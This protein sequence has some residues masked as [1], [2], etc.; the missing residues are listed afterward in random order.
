MIIGKSK[1]VPGEE[2][3]ENG[4]EERVIVARP[5]RRVGQYR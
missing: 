4:G 3:E 2:R 5:W 1:K